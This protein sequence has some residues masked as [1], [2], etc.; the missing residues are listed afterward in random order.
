[1]RFLYVINSFQ[2]GGAE[3]GL[4]T[5]VKNGFFAGHEVVIQAL[6]RGNGS[7]L[8]RLLEAT[9]TSNEGCPSKIDIRW[10][11]ETSRLRD[12][13]L[14]LSII[15]LMVILRRE[16][17]DVLILSL[18]QSNLVGRIASIVI[19][20]AKVVAFEHSESFRRRSALILMRL[21]SHFID[22]ILYDHEETWKSSRLLY[23]NIQ[24]RYSY[25]VPLTILSPDRSPR[26]ASGRSK[27]LIAARLS[28]TKNHVELLHA[29]KI[30]AECGYTF[31]LIIAGEGSMRPRL[32]A[33]VR[34]LGLSGQVEFRGFVRDIDSLRANCDIYVQ[35]SHFEGLCLSVLEAMAAGMLVVSTD[36]GAIRQY[37]K[38][39]LNMIKLSG[40]DRHSI[41]RGLMR[42]RCLSWGE[43][44]IIRNGA[45]RTIEEDFTDS[46]VRF[47]WENAL[48]G[49]TSP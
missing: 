39:G 41:A 40:T 22:S 32:E 37:G 3:I 15:K 8:E 4:L 48:K 17:P 44:E 47:Y 34:E 5:L 10:L 42:V 2:D 14:P 19:P 26:P 45:L 6:A 46:R 43:V 1:M 35:C 16:R 49:L 30:A 24:D 38:D 29:I 33:L 18:P 12:R 31:D 25:Y 7:V 23:P 20:N 9:S 21:T 28:E 11:F 13:D 27:C 36:V